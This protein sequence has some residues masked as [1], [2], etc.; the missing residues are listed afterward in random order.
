MNQIAAAL[1]AVAG[2]IVMTARINQES[3]GAFFVV[4]GS[5]L[6]ILPY[7]ASCYVGFTRWLKGNKEVADEP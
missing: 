2:G 5:I 1:I 3:M 6:F 4:A 7:A